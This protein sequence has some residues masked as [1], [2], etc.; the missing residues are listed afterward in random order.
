MTKCETIVAG[1]V[2]S[3]EEKAADEEEAKAHVPTDVTHLVD[4]PGVPDYW[5]KAIKNH[6]MLQTIVTE[7]D[8]PILENLT[9]LHASQCKLPAPKLT[10]TMTFKENEFF[11]NE[12]LS[13]SAIADGDTN[14]TIEV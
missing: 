13:F 6:A 8:A 14:Q 4:K 1:I 5:A 11:T 7:K 10:I 9:K 3:E 2:K 12:S